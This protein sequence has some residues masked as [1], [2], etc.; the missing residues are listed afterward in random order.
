MVLDTS[1]IFVNIFGNE[2]DIKFNPFKSQL[3]TFGGNNPTVAISMN[4]CVDTLGEQG[5]V[6]VSEFLVYQW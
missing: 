2:W 5:K 1:L 6:F 4:S 3:V